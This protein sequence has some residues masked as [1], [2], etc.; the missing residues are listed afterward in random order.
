MKSSKILRVASD[1]VCHLLA[2][3]GILQ[4]VMSE[5]YSMVQQPFCPPKS[6]GRDAR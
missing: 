5:I 4:I 6:G 3:V 1:I 2:E